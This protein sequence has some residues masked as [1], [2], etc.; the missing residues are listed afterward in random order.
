MR[1]T[2]FFVVLLIAAFALAACGGGAKEPAPAAQAPV[3]SNGGNPATGKTLFSQT[4]LEGNAGCATC[5]TTEAG[6]VLVGPSLAGIATRAGTTILGMSAEEYIHQSI[7]DTNAHLATG[8]TLNDLS[9]QCNADLMP[10][11]WATKLNEQQIK[12]ITAYLLT[13]K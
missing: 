10:K 5:H 2:V 3:A 13:L 4:V 1:K 11:D 12:D 8:C 6:K 7:V 9:L